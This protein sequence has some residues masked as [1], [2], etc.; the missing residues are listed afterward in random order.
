MMDGQDHTRLSVSIAIYIHDWEDVAEIKRASCAQIPTFAFA[1]LQG[2]QPRVPLMVVGQ[3]SPRTNYTPGSVSSFG[4]PMR[5][6]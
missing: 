1:V 6:Y 3:G 4:E 5:D 2:K